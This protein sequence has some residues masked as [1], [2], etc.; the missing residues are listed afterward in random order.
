MCVCVCVWPQDDLSKE[1]SV[2]GLRLKKIEADGNCF[3]RALSD[4]LKVRDTCNRARAHLLLC[5]YLVHKHC[6]GW[7]LGHSVTSSRCALHLLT[8]T[9]SLHMQA[10]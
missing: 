2:L 9:G 7:S 5:A 3:F 10:P 8:K 4:Q 1:L 6:T